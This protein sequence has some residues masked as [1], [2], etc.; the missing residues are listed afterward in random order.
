MGEL[1]CDFAVMYFYL[2]LTAGSDFRPPMSME[3][4]FTSANPNEPRCVTIIIEDD[5][6]LEVTETFNVHL[7]SSDEDVKFIYNYSTVTILD[8]DGMYESALRIAI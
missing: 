3:R 5:H 6:A 1:C 4:T 7:A 2:V 8:N